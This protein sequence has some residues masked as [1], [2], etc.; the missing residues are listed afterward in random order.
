MNK[1]K[2][3]I[4]HCK[5]MFRFETKCR[6]TYDARMWRL[7]VSEWMPACDGDTLLALLAKEEVRV[8]QKIEEVDKIW[9]EQNALPLHVTVTDMQDFIAKRIVLQK[10][11]K[12]L[13]IQ[14]TDVASA[15]Y[16]VETVTDARSA[17]AG[18]TT[19]FKSP[20][21]PVTTSALIPHLVRQRVFELLN[22]AKMLGVARLFDNAAFGRRGTI[23]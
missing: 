8:Q 1:T 23:A 12:K 4:K 14:Y 21:C 18:I 20:D 15:R 16:M 11:G 9:L 3:T 7:L 2:I 19:V 10:S 5:G 13:V 17:V 22:G 6:S